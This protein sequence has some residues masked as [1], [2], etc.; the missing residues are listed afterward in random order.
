MKALIVDNDISR[1]RTICEALRFRFR[2]PTVWMARSARGAVKILSRLEETQWELIFLEH[3]LG[4]SDWWDAQN[5]Q[6]VALAMRE[7]GVR[8]KRVIIQSLNEG[9]AEAMRMILHP[10]YQVLQV[11]FPELSDFILDITV[12]ASR[13]SPVPTGAPALSSPPVTG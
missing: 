12:P 3:D 1:V 9:G 8:A 10:H 13:M 5:G 11:P 2:L 4:M 6:T 7:M